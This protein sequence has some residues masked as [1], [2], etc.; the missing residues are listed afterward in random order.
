MLKIMAA[1]L[2]GDPFPL[3]KDTILFKLPDEFLS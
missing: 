3:K 1:E 2:R